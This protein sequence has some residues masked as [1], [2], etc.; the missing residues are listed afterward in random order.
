MIQGTNIYIALYLFL[1][2]AGSG[3]YL[4]LRWL[5]WRVERHDVQTRPTSTVDLFRSFPATSSLLAIALVVFGMFFL[6]LDLGVPSRLLLVLARPFGSAISFGAWALLFFIILELVRELVLGIFPHK[7]PKT[8]KIL[9]LLTSLAA[10]TVAVYTGCYLYSVFTVSFWHTPLIIALFF[11]SALSSG[12]AALIAIA[13][14][15]VR[16]N[17]HTLLGFLRRIDIIVIIIEL[18]LLVA[19]LISRYFAGPSS[20]Y[21][22]SSLLVGT[23]QHLFWCGVVG[24]GILAPLILG[25]LAPRTVECYLIASGCIIIGGLLLRCSII[26]I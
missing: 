5:E 25:F 1:A 19:F 17:R 20:Q 9:A 12:T 23:Y 14:F 11:A 8:K 22:V 18:A 26:L 24:F 3:A 6:L 15:T 21:L 16:S 10:L 2:G 7:F 13:F 4:V